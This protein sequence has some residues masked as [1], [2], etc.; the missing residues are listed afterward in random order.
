MCKKGA[1]RE[2]Y[3]RIRA[4][5]RSAEGDGR[6]ALHALAAF[7][8]GH[9]SFFLYLSRGTEAGTAALLEGLRRLG[10]RVCAPRIAGGE[11]L[12]VPLT[13]RLKKGPFG[14]LEPEGGEEE[15]CDVAF[16]PLLAFDKEG[17]RLGYGGGYY[18]RYFAAHPQVLR[19]GLAYEG[20]AADKLPR[21]GHDVRLDA[22]VTERG[23]R[24]F[25]PRRGS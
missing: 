12:C 25:P 21:E 16:C 23:V 3:K 6:I 10:K 1:F 13:D 2:E 24:F 17:Y 5:L 18:D 7:A 22:L 11:M 19:V 20:Q 8:E 14:I 15:T 4:G 9:T